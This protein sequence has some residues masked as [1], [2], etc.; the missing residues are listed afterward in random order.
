VIRG[1]RDAVSRR[2]E[3]GA[4]IDIGERIGQVS[5]YNRCEI[6]QKSLRNRARSFRY[7]YTIAAKSLP[8]RCEGTANR[9]AVVRN[10][11]ASDSQL[12]YNPFVIAVKFLRNR[13]VI[14]GQL[15][16]NRVYGFATGV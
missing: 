11:C 14:K 8:N 2:L 15:S 13:F 16:R 9:F 7:H 6:A 1:I 12:Q 10:R 5:L 4:V 3:G